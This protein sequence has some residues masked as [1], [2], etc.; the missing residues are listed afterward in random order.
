MPEWPYIDMTEIPGTNGELF[1]MRGIFADFWAE[2]QVKI[3]QMT[4]AVISKRCQLISTEPIELH[5]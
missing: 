5:L 2:L 4:V 3:F 1:T